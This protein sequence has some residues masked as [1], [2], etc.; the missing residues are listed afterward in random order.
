[1]RPDQ[2]LCYGRHAGRQ[3]G[4]PERAAPVEAE[5]GDR[6]VDGAPGRLPDGVGVV[7]EIGRIASAPGTTEE[8]V[9]A[10]WESL[11]RVVPFRAACI[12]LLDQAYHERP[13][14]FSVG[15]G[16]PIRRY[17]LS[18]AQLEE[19]DLIGY[20]RNRRPV[21]VK[22]LPVPRERVRSWVEHLAPAGFKEGVGVGLFAPDGRHLGLFGLNTDHPGH[23]TE[24]A[25]DLIGMLAPVIANAVDPLR[26]LVTA[27]RMV[28]GAVAG[29]VLNRSGQ[30]LPLAGLPSHPVLTAGSDVLV[31]AA[32]LAR[33]TTH[34]SFLCPLPEA[35]RGDGY[36][37]VTV[38]ALAPGTR[39]RSA[40][41][42]VAA[43][44]G[45]PF[46]LTHRELQI[47]GLLI[48]GWPSPRI[49]EALF[50]AKRTV[51][52]H[53]EHILVKLCASSRAVAATRAL[54]SGTYIPRSVTLPR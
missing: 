40:A 31:A 45:D 3:R 39:G 8:R 30:V 16:E 10:L 26:S 24:A 34:G 48:E 19:I 25:R 46:G 28:H 43:P 37:R 32:R 41:A 27:A 9:A 53:V 20:N 6:A 21:R 52:T 22:D 5:A 38:L 35:A 11:R 7:A 47:L 50:I 15:Y 33:D 18:P 54:R 23:P 4:Q 2:S 51:A 44:Q 12:Y 14:L 42:V 1:M 49:A 13:Q 36:L 17:L 29:V